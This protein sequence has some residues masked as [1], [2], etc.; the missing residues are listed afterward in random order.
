MPF[1]RVIKLFLLLA[2]LTLTAGAAERGVLKEFA[3]ARFES[4]AL[5]LTLNAISN[6]LG[7]QIGTAFNPDRPAPGSEVRLPLDQVSIFS[8]HHFGLKFTPLQNVKG[9][10]VTRV[11][12]LSSMR[13]GKTTEEFTLTI[14][15]DGTVIYGEVTTIKV[16]GTAAK[17]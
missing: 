15:P 8:A 4:G 5:V 14:A 3:A 16:E 17:K 7:M 13:R 1:L 9:F 2:V 11:H 6:G 10:T 12:D